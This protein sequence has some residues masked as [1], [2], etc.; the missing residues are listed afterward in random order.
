MPLDIARLAKTVKRVANEM[1]VERPETKH[2]LEQAAALL[3][4]LTEDP[5]AAWVTRNTGDR[6]KAVIAEPVCDPVVADHILPS[7]PQLELEDS[8][9]AT[10][11]PL[12]IYHL[13]ETPEEFQV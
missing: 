3:L 1:P 6:R 8:V 5:K 10:A 2:D 4:E 11:G 7:L 9:S 12:L 13:H